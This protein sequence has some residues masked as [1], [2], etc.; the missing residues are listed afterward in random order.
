MG[1]LRLKHNTRL[2]FDPTFPE[3]NEDDF[4]Q[5]DWTEFY[6]DVT[7]AIPTN[8]P[9][10]LGKEVDLRMM[11]DSDPDQTFPHWIPHLL[12]YGLD[13]M[14]IQKTTNY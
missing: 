4:P 7:E 1:Y 14:A 9:P 8:M 10:P 12:Q 3:I 6:S 11:V 5:F 13:Y 2:I